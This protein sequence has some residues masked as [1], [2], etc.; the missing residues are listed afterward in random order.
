[1]G[2]QVWGHIKQWLGISQAMSTLKATAKWIFKEARGMG[3]QARA[4]S[5]GFVCTVYYIW[6]ARNERIHEGITK[7]AKDI[8]RRIQIQVYR[9]IYNLYPNITET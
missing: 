4:K 8:I 3:L 9:V 2:N 1:M 5:I 6:E 7:Q